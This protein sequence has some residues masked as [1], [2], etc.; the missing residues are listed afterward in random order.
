[1]DYLKLIVLGAA[2]FLTFAGLSAQAPDW[3]WVQQAGGPSHDYGWDLDCDSSGNS[4]VTG[5]FEGTANFGPYTL[6]GGGGY[7]FFVAKYDALGNLQWAK[8]ITAPV[9]QGN[10]IAVDTSGNCHVMGSFLS[11]AIIGDTTL[12]SA[13][14]SDVFIAKLDSAGNWLW[15]RQIGG[16]GAEYCSRGI[17]LDSYGDIYVT[18]HFEQS[19]AIGSSTLTST[20]GMDVFIAKLD[21]GGNWLWARR[22]GGS[23]YYDM[24]LGIATDGSSNCYVTGLFYGSADFGSTTLNASGISDIFVAK[25]DGNGGWLWARRAGGIDTD[26]GYGIATLAGGSS[27]LAGSFRRTADFGGHTLVSVNQYPD[28]CIARIDSDGN[29]LW[30]RRAGSADYGDGDQ[31]YG[32]AVDPEENCYATGRFLGTADF[33]AT[34]LTSRGS[35]D[36]FVAALDAYGDWLWIKRGGGQGWDSGLAISADPEGY[37][38]VS[39]IFSGSA[40]FS[41][42]GVT[43]FGGEDIF[44]AKL[45]L[46]VENNDP[47]VPEPPGLSILSD[48]YPNPCPRGDGIMIKATVA[49]HETGILTICN[50]RGQTIITQHLEAGSHQKVLDSRSL[51]SGVYLCKLSTPSVNWV[52]KLVLHD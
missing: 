31:A 35:S 36:V 46:T 30:A 48:P 16:S 21:S 17:A 4:Y 6:V 34:I 45:S 1:L 44:V 19:V 18:G 12:V 3:F 2:L 42:V 15:V 14:G 25:L 10:G 8:S 9:S 13:G 39:G 33:G 22:A 38:H 32:I 47:Q 5:Y 50:L 49:A 23:A 29:W 11:T 41:P 7:N 37:L 28:I 24:G 43:S 40:T 51:A 52:R 27:Y 20:G 26:A